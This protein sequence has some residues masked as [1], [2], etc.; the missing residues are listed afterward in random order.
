[1][2][3]PLNRVLEALAAKGCQIK[4]SGGQFMAQCPAHDD[5]HE[6]MSVT[7]G[8][9]GRVLMHDHAGCE[10]ESIVKALGL[11]FVDLFPPKTA[12]SNGHASNGH[13]AALPRIIHYIRDYNGVEIAQH[14]RQYKPDG[15]KD[16]WWC[17]KGKPGLGGIK[18]RDLP[19]YGSELL[20]ENPDAAVVVCEGEPATDALHK[21]KILAVGTVTGA[22]GKKVAKCPSKESLLVLKDKHV[23]LW[24]DDDDAGRA[25]MGLLARGLRGIAKSIGIVNWKGPK[26]KCD[27][28]DFTGTDDELK[29]LLDAAQEVAVA[30][31]SDGREDLVCS[32][33][34]EGDTPLHKIVPRGVGLLAQHSREKIYVHADALAHVVVAETSAAG[35]VRS[36][37]PR[38]RALPRP[39]LREWLDRC[40]RWTTINPAGVPTEQYAPLAIVDAIMQRGDWPGIRPLDGVTTAPVFREDGT[41]LSEPGYDATTRLLYAPKRDYPPVPTD[42]SPHE[43]NVALETLTDPFEDFPTA[44]PA[45]RAALLALL[46]TIAA[47]AAIAGPVPLTVV[48]AHTPGSGKTLAIDASTI[49]MTGHQPDKLMVAGGRAAD[50]DAEMRKR[51][52]TFAMEASR[53]VLIDNAPDGAM[54][55]SPALAAALTSDEL[56]ERLLTTNRRVCVP[57]RIIWCVT[58]NNITLASDLAR[59]SLSILLDAKVED[60]HLRTGFKIPNLL[61]H[62]QREHPRLLVAALTILRGFHYAG[63]P[64]HGG[65]ALGM[66]ESWD[67]LVRACV[68]WATGHD[69]VTTQ[70]R[71]RGQSPETETLG[72]V[73]A[74]WFADLGEA[75]A[76]AVE[77]LVR[78]GIVTALA[79][80][81]PTKTGVTLTAVIVGRWLARFCGRVVGG[82][83]PSK[84]LSLRLDR[85]P[86]TPRGKVLW[87]VKREGS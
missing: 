81:I 73:L 31:T 22:G 44:E 21:R 71:L 40:A 30:A 45:D 6:S 11:R 34:G 76:N 87:L 43:V 55:A 20:K 69:P 51:I 25:H 24:A 37:A 65:P 13:K 47:R 49:A 62:V 53:V 84:N 50:A 23:K 5:E 82:L 8:E 16:V 60:P 15:S 18:V 64:Q 42:P 17:I 68:C 2:T 36:R 38:I 77:L 10:T 39:V 54:V 9:D 48:T 59:R 80:A 35:I 14:H 41:I 58:G 33:A 28:A 29:A 4:G 63:R 3:T 67:H 26:P 1:M 83:G 72:A 78:P 46:L 79:E 86:G 57:H 75:H 70:E 74:A 7:E 61:E 56:T 12:G 32:V 85:A 52:V 66:F 27:A 19:L